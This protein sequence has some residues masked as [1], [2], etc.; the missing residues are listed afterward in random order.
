MSQSNRSLVVDWWVYFRRGH[1]VYLLMV[2]STLNFCTIQ[3]S[4]VIERLPWLNKIFP[5]LALFIVGLSILYIPF[6]VFLGYLDYRRI[7]VPTEQALNSEANPFLSLFASALYHMADG[8]G[9]KAK[10]ILEPLLDINMK[11]KKPRR[12]ASVR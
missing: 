10:E 12:K 9:E 11:S 1:S 8:D 2:L 4:L 7:S 5:N 3:Y 6:S